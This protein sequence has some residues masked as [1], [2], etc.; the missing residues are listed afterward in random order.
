RATQHT[1]ITEVCEE[2]FK[3]LN[4]KGG[5][6]QMALDILYLFDPNNEDEKFEVPNYI[7]IGLNWLTDKL[8]SK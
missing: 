6:T 8:N 7:K 2:V 4:V 5:K 3:A 1:N